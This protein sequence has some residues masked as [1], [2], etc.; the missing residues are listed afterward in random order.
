MNGNHKQAAKDAQMMHRIGQ[1]RS[2]ITD[3]DLDALLR[4]AVDSR[5][6]R[7]EDAVENHC[8]ICKVAFYTFGLRAHRK[9]CGDT[10]CVY[11]HSKVMTKLWQK[12]NRSW[13]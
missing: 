2:S 6:Y 5:T 9:T 7:L 10:E 3:A 8:T 11:Q 13:M 1:D 4:M 12:K